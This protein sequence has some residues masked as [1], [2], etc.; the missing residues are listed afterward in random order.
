MVERVPKRVIFHGPATIVIW[1]DG[2][3][4][5]VKC[6][7][8]ETMDREKAIAMAIAKRALGN[9]GNYYEV[10]KKC[11]SMAEETE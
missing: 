9:K 3:K 11:L 8:D 10:I 2:E 4:T 7:P 6:Q 5:I 1:S